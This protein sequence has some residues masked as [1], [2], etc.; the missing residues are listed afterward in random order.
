VP[1]ALARFLAQ[2]QAGGDLVE[3]DQAPLG[4]GQ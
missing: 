3:Q 2:D 1:Q 4:A